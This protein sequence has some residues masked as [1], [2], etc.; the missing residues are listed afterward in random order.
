MAVAD[1]VV[2]DKYMIANADCVQGVADLPTGSV[3]M[4][5]YSP[6]F[7]TR[8]GA[9]LYQYSS[10]PRDFS[11]C[12]NGDHFFE[13]YDYLVEQ[14]ARVMMAG[15]ISCV[16]CTDIPNSN[17]GR[18]SYSDFP[19]EIIKLHEKHGFQ[20]IGRH[21]IWKE[22]LAVRLRTMQ[23]N[24]AHQTLTIDSTL[25]GVA[26][27]DYLLLFRN[28]GDNPV[29]VSH[30]VGL[31]D[32]CGE[33][34]MPP[35][36]QAFRGYEGKQTENRFSHWIWRQYAS[37][38]WDDIRL[39]RVLPFKAARDSEDEKHVHPLQLDVIERAVILR[40]NPGEVVLTP[41]MGVGSE[42]YG[43][44]EN[45]RKGIGFELKPSYYRQSV[46]NVAAAA[47]IRKEQEG[48]AF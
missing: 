35:E 22:P 12:D 37:S 43:A 13:H 5:I 24:L 11:N 32:Y 18:D 19:G 31:L 9:C 36:L 33:R 34:V 47:D 26:S 3:H 14:M 45:G 44:I 20:Y 38:F 30:P 23:K 7:A 41:F 46:K 6:P 40:S 1:Q 2:T 21:G 27:M 15:R 48:F 25:C 16:H 42:V 17:S 29:P 8:N 10:D 28:K 4:S 39:E